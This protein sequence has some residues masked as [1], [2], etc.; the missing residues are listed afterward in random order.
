M[1][2]LLAI[3]LGIRRTSQLLAR[4]TGWLCV[5]LVLLTVQQVLARYLFNSSSVG[6][7]ELEWHLFGTIFLLSAAHTLAIDEHVRVD[8]V[9]TR[10]PEKI[11]LAIDLLGLLLFA[12]P[13]CLLL[14]YY[15]YG[16]VHSALDFTNPHPMDF[17]ISGWF[18]KDSSLY[19]LLLPIETF[20]RETVLVGEISSDPGGL[21]ARWLIK[22]TI[23]AGAL[24]LLLQCIGLLIEKSLILVGKFPAPHSGEGK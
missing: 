3:A 19:A 8:L 17:Y 22:A 15:G 24:F 23:P 16:F 12:L 10:L 7:Q 18:D 13:T 20:L 5:I 2:T 21:E 4:V 14:L 6:L 9:Y 1:P 11:R